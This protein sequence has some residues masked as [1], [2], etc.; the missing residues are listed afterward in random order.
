MKKYGVTPWGEIFMDAID[1]FDESGRLGRG[2]TYANTGRVLKLEIVNTTV[3]ARVKGRSYSGYDVEIKFPKFS[4]NDEQR[5]YEII[6]ENPLILARIMNREL[7]EELLDLL[8][9]EDI[10]LLPHSWNDMKRS[11]DCPDWGDPCKHMAAVYYM[12]A[13]EIDKNPFAIFL[14]RG[15][16]LVGHFKISTEALKIEYPVSLEYEGV[17]DP[18]P[19]ADEVELIKFTDYSSFILSMLADSPPFSDINYRNVLKQ[20]YETSK[21]KFFSVIYPDSGEHT[22]HAQRILKEAEIKFVAEK[23]I[24]GSYFEVTSDILKDD[25]AA[26]GFFKDHSIKILKNSIQISVTGMARLFLSFDDDSGSHEYR[27]LYYLFRAAYLMGEANG[28]IPCVVETGKGFCV[29]YRSLSSVPDIKK[30]TDLLSA[31]SPVFAGFKKSKEYFSTDTG[32]DFILTAFFT[33]YTDSLNF[34]HKERK[35]NPPEISKVF[36][37]G[38]EIKTDSFEKKALPGSVYSY[39]SVFDIE[40][41][42][43]SFSIRI[44]KDRGYYISIYLIAGNEHTLLSSALEKYD[45]LGVLKFLS[46]LTLYLPEIEK[47][48]SEERTHVDRDRLEE[49]LLSSAS[50]LT[51]LGVD[52]ELPKELRDILRPKPVLVSEKKTG[53]KSHVSYLSLNSMLDYQWK[54]A[55]GDQIISIKEF[56]KLTEQGRSLVEF[57]NRFVRLSPE[58]VMKMF[59]DLQKK[60][61]FTN[62]DIIQAKLAGEIQLDKDTESFIDKLFEPVETDVPENL[63]A[64][65]R[66]YQERGFS[67][68]SANLKNGFGIILADDM[69]LG[70]TIQAIAMILHMKKTQMIKT[71]TIIVAPTTLLFNWEKELERFAPDLSFHSYHG[72]KREIDEGKDIIITTYQLLMRDAEKLKNYKFDCMI[73]DEAQYIKNPEAKTSKAVKEFKAKY[74][75]ALS[76]TPVENNL[77]EM[78]SIFDFAMPGYLKTLKHFRQEFAKDI[79]ISR[80]SE[81]IKKLKQI[82]APFMLRRL[83]TDS[84]IIKDLPEKIVIDEFVELSKQQAALYQGVV[85][86]SIEKIESL[87]GIDRKGMIFKLITSL[88]Q[89]CNHPSN[90]DKSGVFL[91][92]ISGKAMH[93]MTLLDTIIQKGEKVLIFTQYTEMGDLLY[94]MIE[95]EMYTVPLYLKGSMSKKKREETVELFQND[96]SHN[97]FILSLRAAGVGLNLTAATNVI[98]YDLWYNPAVENQATDRAFRIGQ[99]KNVFVHRFIARNTFEEKIN[100]MIKSKQELSDLSVNIG[101][102]WLSE[103]DNQELKEL[104]S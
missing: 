62:L 98:H 12:L 37:R 75:M 7:P 28:F 29:A 65:L 103:M 86:D 83:K 60:T 51:N 101:E 1:G 85:D 95:K 99:T 27:L 49:F 39:F 102:K 25:S 104:F 63:N 40:K 70:K 35:Q 66:P 50:V 30:Q 76:G 92:E 43:Y 77:S 47:L 34:M 16:D 10:Y 46:L 36:F 6:E 52:I 41:S 91:S 87:E 54:I 9:D 69:G 82:T 58:E 68:G 84:A 24:R 89:I 94:K 45:R 19:L 31:A 14:I 42:E 79:E 13:S 88:K 38:H 56:K 2:K 96:S 18:L 5:I 57:K 73:I 15:I 11:C 3:M 80:D 17:K 74:R 26:A 21:K 32:V 90:F 4:K 64:K 81:K 44:E 8:E 48:I 67:W 97:V 23:R 72:A 59:A 22:A 33:E 71:R 100:R 61:K 93:L 78:W 53:S 20:F 55:I